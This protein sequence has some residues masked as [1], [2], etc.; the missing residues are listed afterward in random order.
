M[1]DNVADKRALRTLKLFV[2]VMATVVA[3]TLAAGA[4]LRIL[5]E[6]PELIQPEKENVVFHQSVEQ[7]EKTLGINIL[8]PS[9][10]PEYLAWPPEII[11]SERKPKLKVTL[12]FKYRQ[13]D[14]N[15]L[16]I[17]ESF[18]GEGK[19]LE[20]TPPPRPWSKKEIIVNG[21]LAEM[22]SWIDEEGFLWHKTKWVVQ[23]R[24]LEAQS[25]L[26]EEEFFR[27]VNSISR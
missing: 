8:L 27:I 17:V 15:A 11:R 20:L 23:D 6:V 19:H 21:F 7:A 12:Q 1:Q 18:P 26:P 13:K 4:L 24:H 2:G 22:I 9:Y 14:Q 25:V 5:N 16:T 3:V 10:F